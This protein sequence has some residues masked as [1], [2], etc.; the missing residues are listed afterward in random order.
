MVSPVTTA[1][2]W[3]ARLSVSGKDRGK[4]TQPKQQNQ[5]NG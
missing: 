1:T 5:Q 3:E 4:R 2:G